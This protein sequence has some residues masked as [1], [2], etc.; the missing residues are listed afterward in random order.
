MPKKSLPPSVPV[1]EKTVFVAG[2]GHVAHQPL[3]QPRPALHSA[4]A[5]HA[6]LSVPQ[7]F[8][9]VAASYLFSGKF[10]FGDRKILMRM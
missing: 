4:P 8:L 3:E 2:F 6:A 10:D 1:V 9:Q 5:Q 7:T